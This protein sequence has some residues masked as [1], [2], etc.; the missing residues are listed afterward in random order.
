MGKGVGEVRLFQDSG[1]SARSGSIKRH[2]TICLATLPV[3]IV[4]LATGFFDKPGVASGAQ[5]IA[6]QTGSISGT[7]T[8]EGGSPLDYPI[9]VGVYTDTGLLVASAFT[10]VRGEYVVGALAPGSYKVKFNDFL[11]GNPIQYYNNKPDLSSADLVTVTEGSVTTGIN[12]HIVTGGSVMGVVTDA[13]GQPLAGINVM[14]Y[15][16]NGNYVNFARTDANGSYAIF[17]LATGS[18]KVEFD[19]LSGKYAPQYYDHKS[20][21]ELA[22]AISVIKGS[23]TT[24]INAS[25]AV[26]AIACSG[27][28]PDLRLSMT[29]PAYWATFDDYQARR[30]SVDFTI[31][32][33]GGPD[34]PSVEIGG[35]DSTNGVTLATP[36]P[37]SITG[38]I[39]TGASSGMTLVYDVYGGVYAFE[40]TV[41][42]IAQD[43][44]G[45][46]FVYGVFPG[47]G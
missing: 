34:A 30:L 15:T 45:Q 5:Y 9:S 11:A 13:G 22:D 8:N 17:G 10:D 47:L 31:S 24:G 7:V 23:D 21:L 14:I 36:I 28:K 43:A 38:P 6:S 32:N 1:K 2:F 27:L 42:A 33:P 16:D 18:Y 29:N 37:F 26:P 4:L 41:D 40:T 25:L 3:V 46:W 12:A 19:D 39:A 20:N 44:C 35:S